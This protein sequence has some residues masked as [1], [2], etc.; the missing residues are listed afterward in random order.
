[1]A[2]KEITCTEKLIVVGGSA[3]SLDALLEI[4]PKLKKLDFAVIIV[5]HR[6]SSTDNLLTDLL[7][8]KTQLK[9]KEIEEKEVPLP[10]TIYLVPGNYHLLFEQDKSF[11]LDYSEKVNYSRPS[12]DVVFQ[13][14]SDIFKHKLACV[15]LSGANADGTEGLRYVKENGG[16]TIAQSPSS[17]SVSYMPEQ[18]IAQNVVDYVMDVSLIAEFIN[19]F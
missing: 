5:I 15:L 18:A 6:K 3:G 1:M 4:F 13:S 8:A 17:S 12:I 11:T 16:I 14:A 10:G 19:N 2:Q 9:V 7:S